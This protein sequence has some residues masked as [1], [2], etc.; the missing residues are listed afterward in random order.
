MDGAR[1]LQVRFHNFVPLQLH[2][3]DIVLSLG[4]ELRLHVCFGR[5]GA[6]QSVLRKSNQSIE[7]VLGKKNV[8]EHH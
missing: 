1:Y 6:L 7:G 4:G 3:Y 8:L 5:D 2:L